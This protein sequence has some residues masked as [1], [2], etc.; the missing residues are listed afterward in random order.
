MHLPGNHG[1]GRHV[2]EPSFQR[3]IAERI[4]LMPFESKAIWGVNA[5]T[6]GKRTIF[7]RIGGIKF[8]HG[9][10]FPSGVGPRAGWGFKGAVDRDEVH[11]ELRIRP[12]ELGNSRRVVI[13]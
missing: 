13:D 1:V 5:Q 4:V 7:W 8:R 11:S 6:E 12:F 3:R 9:L 2:S 10:G